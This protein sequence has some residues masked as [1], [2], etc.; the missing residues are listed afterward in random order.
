MVAHHHQLDYGATK[1]QIDDLFQRRVVD[2]LPFPYREAQDVA[3]KGNA[4]LIV[5]GDDLDM[6]D[7][8]EHDP[9]FRGV[10]LAAGVDEET[11]HGPGYGLQPGFT[12]SLRQTPCAGH[13]A[14]G[15]DYNMAGGADGTQPG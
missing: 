13:G 5:A 15:K 11:R 10:L 4:L 6:V 9:S 14:F 2:L 1:L 8:L 3:V 12:T 7:S